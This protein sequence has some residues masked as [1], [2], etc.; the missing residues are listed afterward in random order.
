MFMP[1]PRMQP[2]HNDFLHVSTPVALAQIRE[3]REYVF[4]SMTRADFSLSNHEVIDVI[5]GARSART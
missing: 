2:R 1:L 3:R 4:A 5:N